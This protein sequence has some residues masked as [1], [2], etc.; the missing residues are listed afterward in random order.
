M[1]GSEGSKAFVRGVREAG[2]D[3]ERESP[4]ESRLERE[5]SLQREVI[6]GR[7]LLEEVRDLRTL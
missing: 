1:R 4:C 2:I 3:V 6:W 5:K 7:P